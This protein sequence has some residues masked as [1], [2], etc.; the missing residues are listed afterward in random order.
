MSPALFVGSHMDSVVHGGRFDGAYGAVAGMLIAAELRGA[1][2]M[3]VVGFVTCE[4]EE[5][6]FRAH[7]MGARS[8]LG[9]VKAEELDAVKDG[10]GVTWR[11]AL[12]EARAAGRAAPLGAGV[13][14][15]ALPFGPR[16]C[17]SFISS[18]ASFEQG[19]RSARRHI[20]GSRRLIARLRGAARTGHHAIGAPIRCGGG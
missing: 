2:K 8:L 13:E 15:F 19:R 3:P 12:E 11:A 16:R 17:S 9:R 4:E 18:R 20:A 14:P 1:G 5:S 10:A 7:L 6:R